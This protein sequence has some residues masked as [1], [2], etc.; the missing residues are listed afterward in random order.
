MGPS[1]KT[2]ISL[3]FDLYA[4]ALMLVQSKEE[5]RNRFILRLGELHAVF[6]HL[7]AIGNFIAD[8][9]IDDMWVAADIYGPNF[10]KQIIN[11][12]HMK[13]AVA[14][15]EINLIVIYR[16]LFQVIKKEDPHI[17]SGP[18]GDIQNF[19]QRVA[20]ALKAS[21]KSEF[22]EATTAIMK[23]LQ[24]GNYDALQEVLETKA[25]NNKMLQ[26]FMIYV[27]M[28]ERL[29]IFSYATRSRNWLLHLE[30][31]KD[32]CKDLCSIDR[33]KYRRLW[34]LCIAN[35]LSLE[36]EEPLI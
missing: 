26:F 28:V 15:H 12:S 7:R 30:S 10:V 3:D 21:S 2:A 9:G 11:C 16:I 27:R 13:R 19:V 20:T 8:S 36:K 5:L 33:I 35:M 25:Q 31:G 18:C 14:A 6:A 1:S 23:H 4:R 29:L 34:P 22:S 17:L 24:Q 32:L